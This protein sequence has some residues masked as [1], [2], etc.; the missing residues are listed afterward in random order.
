MP[1]R[2][3]CSLALFLSLAF[4]AVPAFA[5]KSTVCTITVNS[6]DEKEVLRQRL[7]ADQFDFVELVEHGRPD[8]LASACERK[9]K[10]D[11]LVIS[12]HFDAGVQFYS[13]RPDVREYLPVSE[14]EQ[15]ACSDACPGVFANLKEVYLFGCNTLDPSPIRLGGPELARSLTRAGYGP[16]EAQLVAE[17]LAT[18]HGESSRERMRRIFMNVPVIYGFSAAAPL[19]ATAGPLL[20]RYLQNAG[21]SIGSGQP[22]P[23]LLAQFAGKSMSVASGLTASDPEAAYRK[24]VCQFIDKRLSAAQKLGFLHDLLGRDMA[25]VR[26]F[27][28]RIEALLSGL[29]ESDRKSPQ[30]IAAMGAISADTVARDRFLRFEW[31]AD[32]AAVRARMIAVAAQLGWLPAEYRRAEMRALLRDVLSNPSMGPAEVDLVC[33]L[34]A[35]GSFDGEATKLGVP[36]ARAAKAA[37][38]AGL[39]CLGDDAARRRVLASVTNGSDSDGEIAQVYFEHRP[40]TRAEELRLLAHSIVRMPGSSAQVRAI[41]ALGR[42]RISDEESLKAVAEMFPKAKSVE[43]Q[44]AIASLIIRSDYQRVAKPDFVKMLARTRLKSPDGKDVIDVLIR[45]LSA[46]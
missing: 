46:Q 37:A 17:S 32:E 16:A 33:R 24:D 18:R 2:R 9:V 43:V 1:S 3:S 4:A 14:M 5:D 25:E 19:G 13:D 36:P 35:D 10:C 27:L 40:I 30:F 20:D 12:G 11:V 26:L 22:D 41:D 42:H 8:W 39:A 31:D 23:A 38:S 45:R 29:S 6:A 7:P 28:D 21:T 34:D 44:R 15:Q